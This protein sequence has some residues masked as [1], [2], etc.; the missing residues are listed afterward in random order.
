MLFLSWFLFYITITY[1]YQYHSD[2]HDTCYDF[3]LTL[4]LSL[5]LSWPW[6]L[7][8]QLY[9]SLLLYSLITL[10]LCSTS[11]NYIYKNPIE[12]SCLDDINVTLPPDKFFSIP[13]T[14]GGFLKWWYPQV[15]M[16]FNTNS[17]SNDLDDLGYPHVK[18]LS[19]N[20]YVY[21]HDYRY[22]IIWIDYSILLSSVAISIVYCRHHHHR[23]HHHHHHHRFL[24]IDHYRL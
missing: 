14:Y 21:Y 2:H 16:D 6:L 24:I 1:H 17:W 18:K 19:Y 13:K 23:R 5:Y 12:I 4:L 7:S 20:S 11:S 22:G 15:T 9:W 3:S 8:L 10:L